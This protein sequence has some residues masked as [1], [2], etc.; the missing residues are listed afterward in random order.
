MNLATRIL[1]VVISVAAGASISCRKPDKVQANA[2]EVDVGVFKVGRKDL[3]RTLTVSSELVPFQE[4]DVYAKES[5]YIKA[6]NVDYGSHV[7][8]NQ[9]LATLEIPELELQLKQDDAAI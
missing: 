2:T 4:I 5:G 7:K 8:A 6:L 3:S 1:A 9:L